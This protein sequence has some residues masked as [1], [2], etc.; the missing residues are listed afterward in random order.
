MTSALVRNGVDAVLIWPTWPETFS[1]VVHEAIAAGCLV[2]THP[3]SGN[4][5][6]L[7]AEYGRALL[8]ENEELLLDAA[9]SGS[10][11]E[12]IRAQTSEEMET[13]EFEFTGLMSSLIDT[14]NAVT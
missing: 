10:L 7:A 11:A 6:P 3:N 4:V 12:T 13:F 5:A 8:F 14:R 9:L 2:I 1:F